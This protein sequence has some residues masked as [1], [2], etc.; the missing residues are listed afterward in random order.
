MDSSS[1]W[2]TSGLQGASC[3]PGGAGVSKYRANHTVSWST[4]RN[5]RVLLESGCPWGALEDG[6][7]LCEP[8]RLKEWVAAFALRRAGGS[9]EQTRPSWKAWLETTSEDAPKH[10]EPPKSTEVTVRSKSSLT[11][12]DHLRAGLVNSVKPCLKIKIF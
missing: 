12:T 6:L 1:T 4:D 9:E 5:P 8:T 3:L 2:K 10:M 11:Y 7:E